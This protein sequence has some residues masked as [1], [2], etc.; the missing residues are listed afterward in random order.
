MQIHSETPDNCNCDPQNAVRAEIISE[1]NLE[2]V[3]PI[4]LKDFLTG[5]KSFETDYSK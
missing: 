3:G 2:R 1:I 5:I 4:I